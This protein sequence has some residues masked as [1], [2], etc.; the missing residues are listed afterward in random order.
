[1]EK[2]QVERQLQAC[3]TRLDM[4][5][6]RR[7]G[8]GLPTWVRAAILGAG[9]TLAGCESSVPNC[10]DCGNGIECDVPGNTD[11]GSPFEDRHDV[12]NPDA[13]AGPN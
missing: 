3:I 12:D 6:V 13:D 7:P 1:M 4:L 10:C 5:T 11:Y 9:L 2:T 8:R